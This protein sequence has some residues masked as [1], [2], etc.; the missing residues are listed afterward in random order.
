MT[1]TRPADTPEI[2]AV[3]PVSGQDPEFESGLPS[4]NDRPLLA[5]TFEAAKSSR[6]LGRTIIWTD[7]QRIARAAREAG[8]EVP[9]VRALEERRYTMAK[10]LKTAIE[11]LER[12]EPDYRPEWVVRLDV[13]HPFRAVGLIDRAINTVLSQD[14]DSA[15]VAF[16][17]FDAFWHVEPD[18]APERIT[19]DTS[20]PR[21]RRT[22]I[23]R[24]L[25][26]LFSMVHRSVIDRGSLYGERLGIIPIESP[27]SAT[28][29]HA[30][31]GFELASV[32]AQPSPL[33]ER[34][35]EPDLW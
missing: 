4:L 34:E 28:D 20:V 2:L 25:G 7:D 17:E 35:S 6:L 31:R 24:E 8:I 15:F 22:P 27:V 9:R 16:P 11:H 21:S 3:I 1:R 23:Y 13:T 5:Y 19:T 33:S 32:F 12:K 10:V 18:G 26:G 29:L 30:V 14:L